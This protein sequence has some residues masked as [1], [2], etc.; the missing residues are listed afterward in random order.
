M[1]NQMGK[2]MDKLNGHRWFLR[3]CICT[4]IHIYI[5]VDMGLLE[6]VVLIANSHSPLSPLTWLYSWV[7]QYKLWFGNWVAVKDLKS[8]D[9]GHVVNNEASL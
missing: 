1:P 3:I 6:G 4:C 9:Y 8:P 5:Y 7:I 2:D